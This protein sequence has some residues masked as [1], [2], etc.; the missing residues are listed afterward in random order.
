MIAVV[1]SMLFI[2]AGYI[3]TLYWEAQT[4]R[5]KELQDQLDEYEEALTK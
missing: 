5:E 1:I 2:I 3:A 4:K